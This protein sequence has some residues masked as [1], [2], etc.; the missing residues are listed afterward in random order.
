MIR[1]KIA[2]SMLITLICVSSAAAATDI[3]INQVRNRSTYMLDLMKLALRYSDNEYRFIE[4]GERLSKN[5]E[6]EALRSGKIA[7]IWGGT[8]QELEA[9]F[10]P[11]R[12]DGYRGLM[13]LRFL[14]IRKEDQ[15]LFSNIQTPADL[16]SL[17]YG[18]G[19]GWTDGAILE[20]AGL[21]V[22]R[23]AKKKGL[24]HMLEGG[25]FDAFPRGATEAW[26]EADANSDLNLTVDKYLIIK[27]PLP[28]YFFVNSQYPQLARD[29][30]AGLKHATLDGSFDDY[31]FSNDRVQL[32]LEQAGLENRRV[33]EIDNP[34]LSKESKQASGKYTLSIERLIEASKQ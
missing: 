8:S 27:Y 7:V 19:R 10:I 14:I 30:E 22:E 23:S 21:T 6:K 5:A 12:I 1:Y 34:F 20:S 18:Q 2:V 29:I 13:S 33:I 24:Y 25:R 32:F 31:F 9:E 3:G 16:K 4:T 15:H 28:T 11:V 26:L 17:S